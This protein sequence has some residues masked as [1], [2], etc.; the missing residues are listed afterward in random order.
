MPAEAEIQLGDIPKTGSRTKL[1]AETLAAI[2][3]EAAKN[4]PQ[5]AAP[6][7]PPPDPAPPAK[8]ATEAKAAQNTPPEPKPAAAPAPK[9]PPADEPKGVKQVRE[10]LERA[11]KRALEA[12]NSLTATAK[13]KADALTK[14]AELE[15]KLAKMNEELERD[16]KPRVERLKVV[17][18]ELQQREE[19]LKVKD[20][21]ATRE[22]HELYVKPLSDAQGEVTELLAE[23]VVNGDDGTQRKA[24]MDDFNEIIA[25]RSLNEAHEIAQ[26]KFGPVAPS[27]VHL[28]S[29]IRG[30]ERNRSEAVKNAALHAEE[31]EKRQQAQFA[32]QREHLRN[33]LLTAA[34]S[35]AS[36]DPELA[37]PEDDT[38]GRATLQEATQF[39]DRILN[40]DPNMTQEQFV[41]EIAKGRVKMIREPML[42][43]KVKR[44]TDQV[45]E[46][47]EKLKQ[48]ESSEPELRPRGAGGGLPA[49][50][51]G[52]GT[53]RQKLM[54]AAVKEASKMVR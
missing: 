12:Q 8:T 6:T 48:Y 9:D 7:D 15:A 24:T 22:F 27:L 20:Y 10:A 50:A 13:E 25:A 42:A 54:D 51:N 40:G 2:N 3:A 35:L 36:N 33:T 30:L 34:Q 39:A 1:P 5:G 37:V 32:Q 31:Y 26:R 44:L 45:N 14:Q 11:E 18:Q 28:R 29:R 38:E 41:K 52:A 4:A 53:A 17:E 46:L 23:L 21:T 49:S 19:L 43:R 47:T 16:Y